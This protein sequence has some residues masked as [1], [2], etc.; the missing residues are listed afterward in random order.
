MKKNEIKKINNEK[1]ILE[2]AV[3]LFTTNGFS[4]TS[5]SNIVDGSGLARGTFYNYFNTKE[6]I[7]NKLV[8]TLI[9]QINKT[10]VYERS[11]AKNAY[12]FIFNAFYEYATI[13]TTSFYLDLIIKNQSKFRETVFSGSSLNSI[14]KSLEID[15]I[16]SDY[17]KGLSPSQYKMTSYAMIAT[18]IELLIQAKIESETIDLE[19]LSVFFTNLFLGGVKSITLNS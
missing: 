5:I 10:L 11:Q 17:F 6:A 7:W 13:L 9:L 19:K 14:Y 16:N 12:D 18:A 4:E 2:S 8:D 15:L 1:A 3:R